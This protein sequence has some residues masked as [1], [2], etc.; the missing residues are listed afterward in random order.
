[1]AAHYNI[2]EVALIE[3]FEPDK[4]G[5]RA[6]NVRI[7]GETEI[8]MWRSSKEPQPGVYYG[9][10]VPSKS[11][12]AIM[13]KK[14]QLPEGAVGHTPAQNTT[15][16]PA[17]TPAA[18]SV[19]PSVEAYGRLYAACLLEARGAYLAAG[20]P[21]EL[22]DAIHPAATTIFIQC[23][24]AGLH[25]APTAASEPVA[26]DEGPSTYE[27]ARDYISGL[28]QEDRADAGVVAPVIERL[29]TAEMSAVQ[30]VE[31]IASLRAGIAD[32]EGGLDI[33]Y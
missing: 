1:M 33:P 6:Y 19:Q 29:K 20:I 28:S 10:L 22:V 25:D 17:A 9:E 23:A 21:E 13:F 31:L 30:R 4:F 7:D 27:V 15:P 24:R 3:S 26:T 12:K 5:N 14:L 18:R 11:G 32:A 2:T 16:T 8:A